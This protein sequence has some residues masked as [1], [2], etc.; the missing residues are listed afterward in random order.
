[1]SAE[2]PMKLHVKRSFLDPMRAPK[3]PMLSKDKKPPKSPLK[4]WSPTSA[5]EWL[6]LA[7]HH[8]IAGGGSDE[9]EERVLMVCEEAAAMLL[10]EDAK[11]RAGAK[12]KAVA[13]AESEGAVFSPKEDGDASSDE[14]KGREAC[15]GAAVAAKEEPPSTEQ[16]Q[17][18]YLLTAA[19]VAAAEAHR[20][21]AAE[22]AVRLARAAVEAY[23]CPMTASTLAMTC[24]R[25]GM[26]SRDISSREAAFQTA[27]S[28]ITAASKDL[29]ARE[30]LPEDEVGYL[31]R[32]TWMLV[33]VGAADNA[34][35]QLTAVFQQNSVSYMGLLLL[36]L[37]HAAGGD[38]D[39][40]AK[41][42]MHLL[43]VYPGDVVGVV[44]HAV[45]Q[46]KRWIPELA[47]GHGH[48]AAA[49]ELAVSMARIEK[50]S[51]EAASAAGSALK[52]KSL[53]G[54]C[55]H[56]APDEEVE[57]GPKHSA[58]ELK[59]RVVGHWALL[60]HVAARL[61]C[62]TVAEVAIEAGTNVVAQ[63][64]MLY[65]RSFADLQ[66][67]RARLALI[68]LMGS[69]MAQQARRTGGS[70]VSLVR[71]LNLLCTLDFV[72]AAY[73]NSGRMVDSLPLTS[74]VAESS[75]GASSLFPDSDTRLLLP[76]KL[77]DDVAS[78]LL[79][80][81]E[82]CPNHGEGHVLLGVTRLLEASQP[83]LPSDTR[84]NRLQEAARHFM[85]AVQADAAMP[86]A[87]LGA[88]VVAEAQGAMDESFDFYASAAEVSAQAPL[89]PWQY[90]DYLYQ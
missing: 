87:Y 75:H 26:M 47:D 6:Q 10:E 60:S 23:R 72:T 48:D 66:C 32:M 43:S 35:K 59:R 5:L 78:T 73:A 80:A 16:L 62:T 55:I 1:M 37:L 86:E 84:H 12:S 38:Y 4:S 64:K 24:V 69:I 67:S 82:A 71:N 3:S 19:A 2:K 11:S 90:F 39:N 54:L 15:V 46:R 40:A 89:I 36:T 49:E 76:S 7:S 34:R 88:G 85:N 68:R 61:G 57:G 79:A 18:A 30:T 70:P 65:W 20:L 81:L 74:G 51:D 42:V 14:A 56:C 31:L 25:W 13:A 8:L 53:K 29:L 28:I 22:S 45:V 63:S 17:A 41:A 27:V 77:F 52:K 50:L 21:P 33:G 83:N 9:V 44:V 58:G